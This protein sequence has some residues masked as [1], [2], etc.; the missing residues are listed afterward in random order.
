MQAPRIGFIGLG[1]MGSAMAMNLANAGPLTV[2]NRSAGKAAPLKRAGARIAATADKLFDS[3]DVVILMLTD[4]AA[5][6]EVL[7][8]S[9]SR[10][11]ARVNGRVIVHMGTTSPDYSL[12]L[13]QDIR[14]VGGKYVEAPVSGSRKPAEAGQL[15]AMLAGEPAAVATVQQCLTPMCKASISCGAVPKAL[16]MKLAVNILLLASVTGLAESLHFSQ[17]SGLDMSQVVEVL[18]NSQMASDISRLKAPKLVQE[19][20]SAHATITDVLKNSR[21]IAEAAKGLRIATPVIDICTSLYGETVSLGQGDLDMV[22]VVKAIEARTRELQ[23][24]S[25]A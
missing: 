6:D 25:Q 11:R 3:S 1:H 15:V 14:S 22:A 5:I 10:F 21:L 19:D 9:S 17:R 4:G 8:R 7:D 18:A 24:D 16:L 20:F 13:E 2:W 12:R 23:A